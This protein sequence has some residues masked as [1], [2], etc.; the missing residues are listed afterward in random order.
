M[1]HILW[2]IW[3]LEFDGNTHFHMWSKV[4]S[5]SGQKRSNFETHNFLFKTFL[6]CLVLSHDSIKCYLFWLATIRNANNCASKR[7]RHHVYLV[8]GGH[9]TARNKDISLKFCTLVV[10]IYFYTIYSGVLD[11]FKKNWFCRCLFFLKNRNCDF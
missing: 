1:T 11:I 10:G 7:R 3:S 5:S 2:V 9:C 6:S 8:L 4:R